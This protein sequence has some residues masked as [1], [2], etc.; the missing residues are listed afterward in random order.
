[1]WR[2]SHVK[3]TSSICQESWWNTMLSFLLLPPAPR[4]LL[5]ISQLKRNPMPGYWL[6]SV[7]LRKTRFWHRMRMI[8]TWNA[9]GFRG[10]CVV[11]F[12]VFSIPVFFFESYH[13]WHDYYFDICFTPFLLWCIIIQFNG[14]NI[15]MITLYLCCCKSQPV[16]FRGYP[17]A[18]G[19]CAFPPYL[20][21]SSLV[22]VWVFLFI[23]QV[24]KWGALRC[25]GHFEWQWAVYHS[26]TWSYSQ[27]NLYCIFV[28][29]NV[30]EPPACS[31]L[32]GNIIYY[33]YTTPPTS[34]FCPLFFSVL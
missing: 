31:W 29:P 3:I 21:H 18:W 10:Y 25:T 32:P 22:L 30:S 17:C 24:V 14:S 7:S 20:T 26:R 15:P 16:L 9:M 12:F 27:V 1:M 33:L 13:I 19:G 8:L 6:W 28:I 5:M 23:G 11:F 2:G 34:I 4:L